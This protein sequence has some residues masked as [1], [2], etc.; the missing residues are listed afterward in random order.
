MVS[1]EDVTDNVDTGDQDARHAA[2]M[3]KKK[4]A[5]DRMMATKSGEKGLIIVHTGAG[6]GKSSSAFG[7]VLRFPG[8]AFAHRVELA[9]IAKMAGEQAPLA[10]VPGALD[11]LHDRAG[12]AMG[13]A[14]HDHAEGGGRLALA[15]AGMDDDQALFA[16]LGRHDLV[17][18]DLD[19]RHFRRVAGVGFLGRLGIRFRRHRTGPS[20]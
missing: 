14:A 17:A 11:E 3:A 15:G 19:F 1:D 2:K 12:E 16:A 5:R 7:M 8:K 13:N 10:G 6:K 9:E 18:G 4:A 20:A